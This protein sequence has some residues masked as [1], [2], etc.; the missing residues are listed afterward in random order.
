MRTPFCL[1]ISLVFTF[2]VNCSAQTA[3]FEVFQPVKHETTVAFRNKC[4]N[5]ENITAIDWDFGDGE[6]S[7]DKTGIV[8]Y[9]YAKIGK[10]VATLTVTYDTI[11]VSYTDTV[12]FYCP[13]GTFEYESLSECV[14]FISM[15]IPNTLFA[16]DTAIYDFG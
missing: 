2:E 16:A 4:S 1:I 13:K 9:T 5:R 10:Y 14:P 6:H 3:S 7:N 12:D 11:V 15:V 8:S